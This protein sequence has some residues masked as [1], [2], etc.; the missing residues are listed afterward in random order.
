MGKQEIKSTSVPAPSRQYSRGLC[1]TNPKKLIFLSSRGC[2][3]PVGLKGQA[4]AVFRDI[5][6]LL[7]EAGA[8]WDNVVRIRTILKERGNLKS[9]NEEFDQAR[10]EFFNEINLKPPY[11]TTTAVIGGL[12]G[13]NYLVEMEVTAVVD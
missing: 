4:L 8:T 9:D 11:P 2:D 5:T 1:I 3:Q 10:R 13:D 6:T 7:K 12:P